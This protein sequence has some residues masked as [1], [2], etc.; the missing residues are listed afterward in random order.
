M[1]QRQLLLVLGILIAAILLGIWARKMSRQG[2]EAT[3]ECQYSNGISGFLPFCA[4]DLN[5]PFKC[6]MYTSLDEAKVICSGNENCR[7]VVEAKLP[8]RTL[9]QIRVGSGA[10]DYTSVEKMK[11]EMVGPSEFETT[12]LITNL[13]QCKPNKFASKIRA[14]G[15][16][17]QLSFEPRA[18]V[19]GL[20]LPVIAQKAADSVPTGYTNIPNDVLV[21]VP[22]TDTKYA[23]GVISQPAPFNPSEAGLYTPSNPPPPPPPGTPPLPPGG[24]PPNGT[25]AT[26]P[27]G[28]PPG[29]P[30]TA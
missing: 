24:L 14:A 1:K 3:P 21:A 25:L 11:E 13:A 23:N 19:G 18:R 9:Y 2:F 29:P 16:P 30:P 6:G 8:N 5:D 7:G 17:P 15:D 26:P 4:N 12:Y 27:G 28:L 10:S 22:V 20:G